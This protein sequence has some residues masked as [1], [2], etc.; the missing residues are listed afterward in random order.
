V[1]LWRERR[2]PLA[3]PWLLVTLLSLFAALLL[4]WQTRAAP[5]SQLL[6]AIGATALGWP[7]LRWTLAHRWM[8]VR[9]FGSVAVFILVS[10]AFAGLIVK[11][12]PNKISSYRY[13]VD[14]ANRRCPTLPA[15]NPIAALKPQ[16]ILTFVDM[17]PRL[18]AVTPHSAIAGPYHRAGNDILDV[19]HSFRATDPEVAHE[20]MRRHGATML[21]ICPGMSESTVYASEAPK[22][23]YRQLNSGRVPAWLEP[24]PL[25]DKSPFKLWR[26][27]G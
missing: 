5:G 11:N 22:G 3:M 12:V 10:G 15:L 13:K 7:L 17:G 18:I 24:V 2:G 14:L 25:P 9:V 1:A 6:G 16:T 27:V 8:L 26:L 23:F 19:Q 20:V 21:L 4:F